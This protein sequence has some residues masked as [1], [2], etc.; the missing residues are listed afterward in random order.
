MSRVAEFVSCAL[1]CLFVRE[2]QAG[3]DMPGSEDTDG[4]E[5]QGLGGFE[6]HVVRS[7]V[8]RG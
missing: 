3:E 4:E 2:E 1:R 5:P 7:M 6:F 8:D